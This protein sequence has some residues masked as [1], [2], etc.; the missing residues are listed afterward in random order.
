MTKASKSRRAL[1]L[2][3]QRSRQGQDAADAAA[4][5]LESAGMELLRKE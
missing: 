2:V 1:L 5:A 4:A 3:N